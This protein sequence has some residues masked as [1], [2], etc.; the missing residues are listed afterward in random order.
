[1]SNRTYHLII[2]SAEV[3][4]DPL[5]IPAMVES[6]GKLMAAGRQPDAD[7]PPEL[8]A[9]AAAAAAQPGAPVLPGI[10]STLH[11]M[12]GI[13]HANG[14]GH[15]NRMNAREN[16]APCDRLSGQQLM[17]LW[18]SLCCLLAARE[19]SVEDVSNKG[20]MLLRLL[21]AVAFGCTWCV[22]PFTCKRTTAAPWWLEVHPATSSSAGV[23]WHW[24]CSI[25][26]SCSTE[27]FA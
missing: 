19:V 2:P 22:R 16:C 27:E 23:F 17:T 12:H 21:H 7:D 25:A 11:H 1:M 20:C 13:L 5:M 4:A 26:T 15:L 3:L 9:A 18:D 10:E 24:S 8:Q 6:R 14:Y